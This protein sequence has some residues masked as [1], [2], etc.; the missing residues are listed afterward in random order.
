M[1]IEKY[2]EAMVALYGDYSESDLIEI[3]KEIKEMN[4]ISL[5][6]LEDIIETTQLLKH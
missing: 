5:A 3:L 4:R 6:A 1:S 2:G